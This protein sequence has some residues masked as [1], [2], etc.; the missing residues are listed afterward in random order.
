IPFH[1]ALVAES[2]IPC[3]TSFLYGNTKRIGLKP[4]SSFKFQILFYTFEPETLGV[5]TL[6]A[7]M[8]TLG[9]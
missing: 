6:S 1:S 5:L 9:T 3:L 4:K 8:M 2:P 7:E